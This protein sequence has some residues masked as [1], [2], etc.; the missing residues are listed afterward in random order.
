MSEYEESDGL[1]Q[2]DE[3]MGPAFFH[4]VM[5]GLEDT[6]FAHGWGD[7]GMY[8]DFLAWC[9][10]SEEAEAIIAAFSPQMPSLL[11]DSDQ[12]VRMVSLHAHVA[13]ELMKALLESFE[14]RRIAE[15][16]AR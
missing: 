4:E 11:V 1:A 12:N 15:F 10:G 6:N 9:E 5:G 7:P 13:T 16:L 2:P 14:Q 8:S 3:G